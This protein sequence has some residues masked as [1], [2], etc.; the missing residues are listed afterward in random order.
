M[1]SPIA[2]QA[3]RPHGCLDGAPRL[4]HERSQRLAQSALARGRFERQMSFGADWL[5]SIEA[6]HMLDEAQK[7]SRDGGAIQEHIPLERLIPGMHL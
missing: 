3:A 2:G 7:P 1:F 6:F 4:G 5:S